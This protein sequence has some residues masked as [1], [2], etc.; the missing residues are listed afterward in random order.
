MKMKENK[1]IREIWDEILIMY[2]KMKDKKEEWLVKKEIRIKGV[3]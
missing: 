2:F 1:V 3:K